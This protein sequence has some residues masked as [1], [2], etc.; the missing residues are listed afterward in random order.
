GPWGSGYR[1]AGGRPLVAAGR[2]GVPAE[3]A[4]GVGAAPPAPV[5]G[6]TEVAGSAAV[7]GVDAVPGAYE[8]EP[9]PAGGCAT[10]RS[11][12]MPAASATLPA[13]S[14]RSARIAPASIASAPRNPRKTP[15]PRLSLSIT[16]ARTI[17]VATT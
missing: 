7:V 2:A 6:W 3:G 9:T 10:G 16:Y 8:V 12:S 15:K 14:G 5:A 13:R 4:P 1:P 17:V 11:T